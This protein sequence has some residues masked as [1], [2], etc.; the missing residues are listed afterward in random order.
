MS[1]IRVLDDGM[2]TL[3]I[4]ETPERDYGKIKSYQDQKMYSFF[5]TIKIIWEPCFQGCISI[6][7]WI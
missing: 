3:R 5:F 7:Y 4:A 2:R 6:I 1:G